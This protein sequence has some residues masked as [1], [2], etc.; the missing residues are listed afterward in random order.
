MTRW[1]SIDTAPKDGTP[2]W[3]RRK[4]GRAIVYEGPAVWRTQDFPPL[5][6]AFGVEIEPGQQITWWCR[7]DRPYLVA[8]PTHWLPGDARA[9]SVHT[10]RD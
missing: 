9:V 1:Q 6:D 7:V 5:R 2:I 8:T 10:P 3:V 4:H